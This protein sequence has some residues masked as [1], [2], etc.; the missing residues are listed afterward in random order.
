MNLN[1]SDFNA[2]A[3]GKYNMG[4]ITLGKDNQLEKVNN[5]VTLKSWNKTAI[6]PATTLA[7][8][9]AFVKALRDSGI[10]DEDISNIRFRL[11]LPSDPDRE[12]DAAESFKLTPLSRQEVRSILDDY[13]GRVS[14][15]DAAKD[16]TDLRLADAKAKASGLSQPKF[17]AFMEAFEKTELRNRNIGADRNYDFSKSRS[18]ERLALKMELIEH[19]L[20]HISVKKSDV[21]PAMLISTMLYLA[22]LSSGM[23]RQQIIEKAQDLAVKLTD[24]SATLTETEKRIQSEINELKNR[25]NKGFDSY[26]EFEGYVLSHTLSQ[27]INEEFEPL[28]IDSPPINEEIAPLDIDDSFEE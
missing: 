12:L 9:N 5:H 14:G 22:E 11:G 26:D 8:K 24:D 27:P 13:A 10:K 1:L 19:G 3:S 21:R 28:D 17:E 6:D 16:F 25:Y 4:Q 7:V 20:K 2:I 18:K 15:Q 23:T